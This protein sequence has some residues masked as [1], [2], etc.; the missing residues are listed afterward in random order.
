MRI[1]VPGPKSFG[2]IHYI[3]LFSCTFLSSRKF[4]LYFVSSKLRLMNYQR[5][6]LSSQLVI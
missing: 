5:K 1:I 6:L 3:W 4:Q 2:C